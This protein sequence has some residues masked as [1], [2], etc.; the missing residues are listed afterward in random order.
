MKYSFLCKG[1]NYG[2]WIFEKTKYLVGGKKKNFVQLTDE[3]KDYLSIC[4]VSNDMNL[5]LI[6]NALNAYKDR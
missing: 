5:T 4:S 2:Y 3:Q 1:K 6:V